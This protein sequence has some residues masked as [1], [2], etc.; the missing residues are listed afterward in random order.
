MEAVSILG[1]AFASSTSFDFGSQSTTKKI[2]QLIPVMIEHRL[3][4][5]PDESYSLHR[6]MSGCFLLC[7]KLGS[8]V[9]CRPLFLQIWNSYTFDS[10]PKSP[11]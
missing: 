1:E 7:G 3:T 2:N 10:E 4:P 6:K 11:T 9:S 5:P 8:A